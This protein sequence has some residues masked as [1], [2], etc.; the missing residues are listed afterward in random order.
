MPGLDKTIVDTLEYRL[1]IKRIQ[2]DTSSDFIFS[3]HFNLVYFR[4]FEELWEI[5][6]ENLKSGKYNPKL[7]ITIEVIKYSGFSRP[8]SILW[9]FDRLT[10]QLLIDKIAIDAEKTLNR[11]QVFSNIL[12]KKDPHGFMFKSSSESYENFKTALINTCKSNKYSYVLKT[13]ISSFFERLYQHVLINSLTASNCNNLIVKL[14]EKFLLLLT[15]KDSHG[16]IQGVSPSDF[17][18][19]FYLSTLDASHKLNNIKL[20]RYVDDMYIFFKTEADASKHKVTLSSWLRS[21]GLNIN[22]AK[23]KIINTENLIKEE[24]KIDKLFDEAKTEIWNEL[25]RQDLYFSTGSFI[26]YDEEFG[27]MEIDLPDESEHEEIIDFE[28]TKLLFNNFDVSSEIRT[29]IDKFCL[30][31]FSASHDDYAIDYVLE[32]FPKNMHLSQIYSTYLSV[33]IKNNPELSLNIQKL[34]LNKNIYYEYQYLWI[35]AALY[36][37]NSVGKRTLTFALKQLQNLNYNEAL[38]ALCAIIIG[39]FGDMSHRRILK[40][41]YQSEP[42]D[43][44]KSA[45]LFSS[46]NFPGN[47]RDTCYSAWSGHNESNALIV[48]ALKK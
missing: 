14:L 28:G 33:F 32:Q 6:S 34:L 23:T 39:K 24:T 31:A 25:S 30:K 19:N 29:N 20:F 22:E 41:H 10:Y 21:E 37:S 18:G 11:K 40:K 45:I 4:A 27:E 5:L 8:G 1:S 15:Q 9:P 43:Y 17:L 35:Y 3:P 42:S 7:P 2:N 16:I 48:T 47:E 38:R 36:S 44:V 12:L 46:K 26:Y 13:D